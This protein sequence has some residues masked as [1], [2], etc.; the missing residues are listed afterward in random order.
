M[1]KQIKISMWKQVKIMILQKMN[2]QNH[3][4]EKDYLP[5]VNNLFK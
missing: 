1:L 4:W 2:V 3:L 5:E